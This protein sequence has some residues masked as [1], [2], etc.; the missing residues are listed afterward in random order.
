[1]T[2]RGSRSS[3]VHDK[4]AIAS[5][6]P[7]SRSGAASGHHQWQYHREASAFADFAL[8]TDFASLQFHDFFRQR[9]TE[10]RSLVMPPKAGFQMLKLFEE[11][12]EVLWPY[13]DAGILD[14]QLEAVRVMLPGTDFHLAA[15][16]REVDRVGK[17]IVKD[18]PKLLRVER[19]VAKVGRHVL[20]EANPLLL[21][22]RFG[23]RTDFLDGLHD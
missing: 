12:T 6:R 18:L 15:I 20:L 19:D 22:N 8:H 13:A 4:D 14:H 3:E 17:K 16:V 23:Y 21:S 2:L 1:M 10:S 7:L 9:Q 11:P 5:P